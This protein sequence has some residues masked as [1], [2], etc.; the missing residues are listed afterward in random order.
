[1]RFEQVSR[2]PTLVLL[3]VVDVKRLSLSCR[4]SRA[5]A[6]RK[7]GVSGA[8]VLPSGAQMD[9]LRVRPCASYCS[10]RSRRA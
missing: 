8:R 10:P 6:P 2:Y 4:D 3:C 7:A 5:D 9:E 1:V